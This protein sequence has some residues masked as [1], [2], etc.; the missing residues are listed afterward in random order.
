LRLLGQTAQ[1]PHEDRAEVA[2]LLLLVD[3]VAIQLRKKGF[4]EGQL[5]LAGQI[6]DAL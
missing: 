4:P 5:A 1:Q 3:L 2:Q 6:V